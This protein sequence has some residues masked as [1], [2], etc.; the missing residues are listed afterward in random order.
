MRKFPGQSLQLSIGQLVTIAA[1][2]GVWCA[3]SAGGHLPDF[4]SVTTLMHSSLLRVKSERFTYSFGVIFG[5]LDC[6]KK[7][8]SMGKFFPVSPFCR[9]LKNPPLLSMVGE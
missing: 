6:A 7:R 1:A 4:R 3:W 2:T 5:V 9:Y 8:M